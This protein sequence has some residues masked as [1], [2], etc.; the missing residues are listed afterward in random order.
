[1]TAISKLTFPFTRA[2]HSASFEL[3]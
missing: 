2:R 1:M 3:I